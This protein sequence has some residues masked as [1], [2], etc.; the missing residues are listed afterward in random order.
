MN[1]LTRTVAPE[2]TAPH[3]ELEQT[4]AALRRFMLREPVRDSV[5]SQASEP[6]DPPL[7]SADPNQ[8]SAGAMRIFGAAIGAWWAQNP[9]SVLPK[10]AKPLV[11]EQVRKHPWSAVGLAATAGAAVVL[12]RP[13]RHVPAGNLASALLRTTSVS[14]VAAAALAALQE[15][16]NHENDSAQD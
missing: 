3:R 2:V 9:L 7:H 10:L 1:T 12:L 14:A 13:W 4:R 16:M 5:N 8:E 15:S 6:H 11:S